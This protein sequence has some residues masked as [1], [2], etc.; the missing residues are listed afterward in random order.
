MTLPPRGG[1]GKNSNEMASTGPLLDER[2]KPYNPEAGGGRL[3]TDHKV[4][5]PADPGLD[6]GQNDGQTT[7]L[8]GQTTVLDGQTTVLDAQTYIYG[9]N[10][11]EKT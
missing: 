8:K 9:K 11:P 4:L 10:G 2:T 1:G 6:G 5:A 3:H 7:A